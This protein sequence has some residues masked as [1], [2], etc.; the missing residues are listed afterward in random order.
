MA[1]N[2]LGIKDSDTTLVGIYR[3]HIEETF[4]VE[5]QGLA[6]HTSASGST[7]EVE[8]KQEESPEGEG[9]SEFRGTDEFGDGLPETRWI[10]LTPHSDDEETEQKNIK[11]AK[12]IN[13][14]PSPRTSS[15]RPI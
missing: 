13:I 5:I 4:D 10:R 14:L 2:A 15:S 12:V 6:G 1:D 11:Q 3:A 7:Q 8:K 9:L